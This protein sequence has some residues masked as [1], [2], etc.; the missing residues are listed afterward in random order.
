MRKIGIMGG[1]FN[2]IHMAHLI[3]AENAYEQLKLNKVLFM[4]SKKPPHKLNENIVSDV[5]RLQMIRLAIQDNPHFE[6]SVIELEREGITY[7]AET[8]KQL[9]ADYPEDE[10]YFIMGADS[11][12]QMEDWWRPDTIMQLSH[13]VAAV[14]DHVKE[15]EIKNQI[16]YLTEKFSANIHL[17]DTPNMDISSKML[18]EDWIAGKSIRYYV[19]NAVLN[20]IKEQRLYQDI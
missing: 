7:T 16:A 14:R 4:P 11:L 5:H 6:T 12:F 15:N 10:F 19:P 20:Y 13:I 9:K 2:P 18:R 17:L 1:T 3:L 8:L